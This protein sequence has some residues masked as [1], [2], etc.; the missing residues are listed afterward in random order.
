MLRDTALTA[1]HLIPGLPDDL[2]IRVRA[3]HLN[4]KPRK[5]LSFIG[6]LG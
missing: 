1:L 5:A 4:R 6:A 3:D 2:P